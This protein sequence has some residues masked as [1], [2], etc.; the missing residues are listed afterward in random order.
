MK[1]KL[2]H[3]NLNISEFSHVRDMLNKDVYKGEFYLV[4][5]CHKNIL[6]N[7]NLGMKNLKKKK[8]FM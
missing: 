1:V 8:R 3:K 7:N 5:W 2:I 6:I 4:M